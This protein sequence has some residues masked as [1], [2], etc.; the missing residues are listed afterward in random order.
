MSLPSCFLFQDE[1]LLP[2]F[3]YFQLQISLLFSARY[4]CNQCPCKICCRR[5]SHSR[6]RSP[7]R[8]N[9]Q[10]RRRSRSRERS[11][12]SSSSLDEA[13][14]EKRLREMMSNADWRE[15]QRTKN[16]KH[17]REMDAKQVSVFSVTYTVPGKRMVPR[18]RES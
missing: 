17:Y 1:I 12:K 5:P 11:K 6:S 8:R 13:E 18:L 16:V 4:E 10:R 14:R 2:S 9:D 7:S 15:S 3:E